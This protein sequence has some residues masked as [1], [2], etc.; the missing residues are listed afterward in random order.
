MTDETTP[1]LS[2]APPKRNTVRR[3]QII[4]GI[5][6]LVAIGWTALWFGGRHYA[7]GQIAKTQA[8]IAAN[9]GTLNCGGDGGLHG[10]PFRFTL[11]CA[12]FSLNLPDRSVTAT[13][14]GLEAVTLLYT[15]GHAIAAAKGPLALTGPNG[16]TATANW[17]SLQS[18]VHLGLSGLS[19]FS[20]VTD[21]LDLALSLPD[22]PDLPSA[23]TA[24]HA[25]LHLTGEDAPNSL[26]FWLSGDGFA[27]TRPGQAS[28]PPATVRVHLIL[29]GAQPGYH[30]RPADVLAAWTAAG[31]KIGVDTAGIE[32]GGFSAM[33]TGD[34][35][36][37]DD[38]QISGTLT[39][40]VD[41]L[42]KLPALVETLRPG[43][44]DEVA[45]IIGPLGMMLQ[46]VTIDGQ[47]WRQ[48]RITINKGRASVGF[49]PIGKLPRVKLPGMATAQ[50]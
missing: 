20:L 1:P 49:I 10:F 9:G 21:G 23:A 42:D 25:E 44:G 22:K 19:R 8:R 45:R 50:G 12:P 39:I 41:Q 43:K 38:G 26:G 4:I 3:F 30:S 27:V 47:A 6:I 48:T 31:R 11:D 35:A 34:L 36:I 14:P 24:T 33:A 16:M 5:A 29:P 18:S 32:L 28:L 40:R 15:P 37:D 7:E 13:L 17:Q 2:P 46:P